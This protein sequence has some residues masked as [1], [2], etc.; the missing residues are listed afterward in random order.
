MSLRA[1]VVGASTKRPWLTG[2]ARE[3]VDI[4]PTRYGKFCRI[5]VSIDREERQGVEIFVSDMCGT[6]KA[7]RRASFRKVSVSSTG[8]IHSSNPLGIGKCSEAGA[9]TDDGDG[10]KMV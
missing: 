4:L 3:V 7:D 9:E 6:F 2:E 8:T 10:E 1:T 5:T